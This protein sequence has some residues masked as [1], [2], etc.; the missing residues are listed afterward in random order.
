MW[1][2]TR[3]V[4]RPFAQLPCGS[5]GAHLSLHHTNKVFYDPSQSPAGHT[6][7]TLLPA[8]WT[9]GFST[10]S[11]ALGND[12]LRHLTAQL[13]W[14]V[15]SKAGS[16][17][18]SAAAQ[19]GRTTKY[20]I[21][22]D[23]LVRPCHKHIPCLPHSAPASHCRIDLRCECPRLQV[24]SNRLCTC[25]RQEHLWGPFSHTSNH[26]EGIWH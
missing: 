1:G 7:P 17:G 24:H 6:P 13:P 18:F 3:R 10:P 25:K 8:P 2:L 4:R 15:S 19:E 26:F 9:A 11:G 12:R 22:L 21:Q 20:S 14:L 16:A 5:L 23:A